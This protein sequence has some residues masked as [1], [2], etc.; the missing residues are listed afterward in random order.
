MA[1]I[2][3]TRRLGTT[4]TDQQVQDV[5]NY[6]AA[7][8]PG[9][10]TSNFDL[11]GTL[12]AGETDVKDLA[13]NALPTWAGGEVLT[14]DELAAI[15]AQTAQDITVAAGGNTGLTQSEIAQMLAETSSV[16]QQA[17]AAATGSD[18]TSVAGNIE[19]WIV[20]NWAWLMVGGVAFLIVRPDKLL[21]G[22]R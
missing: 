5:L 17:Q 1:Y 16:A 6:G 7:G 13:L 18:T 19:A 14:P 9:G 8:L 20:S 11:L 15:Q 21:F 4:L 2:R 10:S 12:A 3:T 22:R